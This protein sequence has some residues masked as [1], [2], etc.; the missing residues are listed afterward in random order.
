MVDQIGVN[1]ILQVSSPVIREENIDGFTSWVASVVGGGDTVVDGVDDV[2]VRAEKSVCFDLFQ[3]ERN[4]FLAERAPDLF[5][6]IEL[7]SR[8]VL[9]EINV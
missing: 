6:S 5:E 7:G 3:G 9:D 8:G 4:G 2:W 1:R